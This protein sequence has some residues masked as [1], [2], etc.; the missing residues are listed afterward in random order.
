MRKNLFVLFGTLFLSAVIAY[1]QRTARD[2]AVEVSASV[3]TSPPKITLYW[4]GVSANSYTIY[5]RAGQAGWSQI[6]SLGGGAT[7]YADTSVAP[8]TGYEY[9]VVRSGALTAYGFIYSGINLPLVEHR[10]RVILVVDASHA[11]ALANDLWALHQNL[12]GDGWTVS[13]IDVSPS[14]SPVNIRNQIKG[15][16]DSNPNNTRAVLLFGH[17]PVPYSGNIAPDAHENH[18]GAWP[19]DVYY[20]EMH[21]AWTDH[22][23]NNSTAERSINWNVPGDGKFDQDQTPTEVDLQ[24]GRIDMW[25][26]TAFQ[27][28]SPARSE[29]DLLRQYIWKN[30]NFRHRVFTL[31]RRG[32]VYDSFGSDKGF[33]PVANSAWRNYAA[34]FGGNTSQAVGA[35]GYIPALT[36]SGYLWAYSAGGGQY[37]TMNGIGDVNE[38]ARHSLQTVFTMH[39]GSYFG[40]WNNENNWLRSVLGSAGYTLTAAYA[41]FPHHFYH[42]MAMGET[43]GYGIRTSQNNSGIYPVINQGTRQV[44]IALMGDPTLRLQPV[45]P[46]SNVRVS[47]GDGGAVINWASSSDSGILGYNVYRAN[48]WNNFFARLN[49]QLISGTSF[50]DS[51]VTASGTYIYMVRA[52]KLEQSASGTYYNASQGVF[53]SG[54]IAPPTTPAPSPTPTPAPAPTP[55]PTPTPTPAPAPA[56]PPQIEEPAVAIELLWQ[57]SNGALALWNMPNLNTIGGANLLAYPRPGSWWRLLGKFDMNRDGNAD[58]LWKSKDGY[59]AVWLIDAGGQLSSA[60]YA[61][62]PSAGYEWD[63]VHAG[64]LSGDGHVDL[65]WQHKGTGTLALWEMESTSLKTPR[66]LS[67]LPQ[68]GNQWKVVGRADINRDGTGDLIWQSTAGQV[69]VWY[70][71]PNLTFNN[72]ALIGAPVPS[73]W[74]LRAILDLNNDGHNDFLWQST[75]GELAVWFMNQAAITKAQILPVTKASTGWNLIE[76]RRK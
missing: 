64:D 40:D 4:P 29:R 3:Q 7:S 65:L 61:N 74:K 39:L 12:I 72:S 2:F 8:G 30:H 49:Q 41:G 18:R 9:Q 56:P 51:S 73:Y 54:N 38:F 6:A 69:G 27:N 35:G 68:T 70:M 11:A 36:S 32:L 25:A 37:F 20:G 10:G 66:L 55:S 19:A 33:D 58:Y 1:G 26:L 5:R 48:G 21:G 42:H 52:V 60:L 47:A 28:N 31:P 17:I 34:M 16:Y 71:G 53:T 67:Q 46:P 75:N 43:V 14:D 44:H 23:V 45:I 59:L 57:N 63:V 22:L 62:A 15:I 13:R 76:A 24:V 50:T